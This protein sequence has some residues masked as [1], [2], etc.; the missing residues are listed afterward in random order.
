MAWAIAGLASRDGVRI[1]DRECASVSY[2][3]FWN[4]LGRFA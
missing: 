3:G 4:D 2:P 1:D